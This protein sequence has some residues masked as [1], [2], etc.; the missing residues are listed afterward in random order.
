MTRGATAFVF[1]IDF[2]YTAP[3]FLKAVRNRHTRLYELKRDDGDDD[4][5]VSQ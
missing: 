4:E 2:L 3:L 1:I 5:L